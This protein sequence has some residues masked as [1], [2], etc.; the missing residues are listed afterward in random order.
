MTLAKCGRHEIGGVFLMLWYVSADREC[1]WLTF[2]A[3]YVAVFHFFPTWR[4]HQEAAERSALFAF[5]SA[6][7]AATLLTL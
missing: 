6:W 7:S 3:G 5:L 4:A 2:L 1:A